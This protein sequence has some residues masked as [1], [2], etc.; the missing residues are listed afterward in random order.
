MYFVFPENAYRNLIIIFSERW[1]LSFNNKI[2]RIV[3]FWDT[4]G[5]L[6]FWYFVWRDTPKVLDE[7]N[8]SCQ[9]SSLVLNKAMSI[10]VSLRPKLYEYFFL[11]A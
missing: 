11:I 8:W 2:P 10:F 4:E 9:P 7:N 6:L 1:I 5:F 3:V